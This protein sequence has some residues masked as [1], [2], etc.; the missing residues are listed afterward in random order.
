MSKQDGEFS[1]WPIGLYTATMEKIYRDHQFCLTFAIK[2][3]ELYTK[4]SS[5]NCFRK[6]EIRELFQFYL[7]LC[8]RLQTAKLQPPPKGMR[9]DP[10][11]D[12]SNDKFIMIVQTIR[13]NRNEWVTVTS[14]PKILGYVW[15]FFV[16]SLDPRV[17]PNK[18]MVE[19]IEENAKLSKKTLLRPWQLWKRIDSTDLLEEYLYHYTHSTSIDRDNK[20]RNV[21][22]TDDDC[23]LSA[24]SL[25][26]I[27]NMCLA[28][29]EPDTEHIRKTVSKHGYIEL[30]DRPFCYRVIGSVSPKGLYNRV[31]PDVQVKQELSLYSS[32]NKMY[33]NMSNTETIDMIRSTTINTYSKVMKRL[34]ENPFEIDDIA[35]IVNLVSETNQNGEE[36]D[37]RKRIEG[38]PYGMIKKIHDHYLGQFNALIEKCHAE[39]P[40]NNKKAILRIVYR[41]MQMFSCD[42][43]NQLCRVSGIDISQTNRAIQEYIDNTGCYKEPFVNHKGLYNETHFL[44]NELRLYV[45]ISRVYFLAKV[46]HVVVQSYKC[47]LDALILDFSRQHLHSITHSKKGGTKKS[48]AHRAVQVFFRILD[49]METLAK[50]TPG[51]DLGGEN[52]C[53]GLVRYYDDMSI[54]MVDPKDFKTEQQRIIKEIITQNVARVNR[55]VFDENVR[56]YVKMTQVCEWI[57]SI[58]GSMNYPTL[59]QIIDHPTF[60]RFI[61]TSLDERPDLYG[62]ALAEMIDEIVYGTKKAS[63][64]EQFGKRMKLEQA[65]FSDIGNMIY[66]GALKDISRSVTGIMMRS[67]DLYLRDNNF[68]QP[69]SW[70]WATISSLTDVEVIRDAIHSVFMNEG[71]GREGKEIT[72][73]DL[74][75]ID[76]YL[77]VCPR[78]FI[79]AVG[80]LADYIIDPFRRP[81]IAA[82]KRVVERD[83]PKNHVVYENTNKDSGPAKQKI[84]DKTYHVVPM[85][86]L[87]LVKTLESEMK[88]ME[89]I[90]VPVLPCFSRLLLSFEMLTGM[91]INSCEYKEIGSLEIEEGEE[92]DRP[93][94]IPTKENKN[95]TD[96]ILVHRLLIGVVEQT[97]KEILANAIKATLNAKGQRG[98]RF[99]FG[100]SAVPGTL[101]IL[102]VPEPKNEA[103]Y[104]CFG[105]ENVRDES[106]SG[107]GDDMHVL[108]TLYNLENSNKEHQEI[109]DVKK[110][111]A[112]D[113]NRI[114]LYERNMDL[115]I[116]KKPIPVELMNYLP[117]VM[118]PSDPEKR[119]YFQG[120]LVDRFDPAK[121]PSLQDFFRFVD[122]EVDETSIRDYRYDYD[123]PSYINNMLETSEQWPRHSVDANYLKEIGLFNDSYDDYDME[124]KP[125]EQ[126][127]END[128]SKSIP[129]SFFRIFS[130]D[131]NT[132][133]EDKKVSDMHVRNLDRL[134][135]KMIF[136][137]ERFRETI[138]RIVKE[139][140]K[141]LQQQDRVVSNLKFKFMPDRVAEMAVRG[142]RINK[143]KRV[144]LESS[145]SNEAD[146]LDK[147]GKWN[148]P[149]I[150]HDAS[151]AAVKAAILSDKDPK[152]FVQHGILV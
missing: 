53:N 88:R 136:P 75:D 59:F 12:S 124:E 11:L 19:M 62:E 8:H 115:N 107:A 23:P 151:P 96:V 146:I 139:Q 4:A 116:T 76:R 51:A 73:Y 114:G 112:I 72:F 121:L 148:M 142:P 6:K 90:D 18:I 74:L 38:G 7:E 93:A 26:S 138:F 95:N 17:D 13:E 43:Y 103:S 63:I 27:G 21:Q 101:E 119:F 67:V 56:K 22:Q 44:N 111:L 123:I 40:F 10:T 150:S 94:I 58:Q 71:C 28:R 5:F 49:T 110:V 125:C 98:G 50:T 55:L 113:L 149:G 89:E 81:L 127:Y 84:K 48:R 54:H 70:A 134:A 122:K 77:Y 79:S 91:T 14:K 33:K 15:Y 57:T 82:L 69:D 1:K 25:F 104:A 29:Q 61:W 105:G 143:R 99:P 87:R 34:G 106:G 141:D 109:G 39:K 85:N 128:A 32:L 64:Q 65:L 147:V 108:S 102:E 80:Q 68:P 78:H 133:V 129:T 83:Y 42:A 100:N 60:R 140:P 97:N 30:L 118:E 145:S 135:L 137:D 132:D 66:V 144:D 46:V 3:T 126:P 35:E 120:I 47:G 152:P 45:A 41:A 131:H 31:L 86:K 37:S 36:D 16:E 24:V 130:N 117:S 52:S 20:S 2:R 9:I 92:I